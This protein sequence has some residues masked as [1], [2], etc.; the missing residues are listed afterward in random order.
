MTE[1]SSFPALYSSGEHVSCTSA[2]Y[3]AKTHAI[4]IH[5]VSGVTMCHELQYGLQ[6]WY[7]TQTSTRPNVAAQ[8]TN[9]TIALGSSTGQGHQQGHG[10]HR[11]GTTVPFPEA[12]QVKDINLISSNCTEISHEQGSQGQHGPWIAT[13]L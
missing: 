4:D 2:R 13:W 9:T 3:L 5:S 12:S 10:Q 8:T 6:R 11:P 1:K 7:R